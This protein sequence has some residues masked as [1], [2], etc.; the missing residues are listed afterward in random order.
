MQQ[1]GRVMRY[2]A[3]ALV[4]LG[5]AGL[6]TESRAQYPLGYYSNG[7]VVNPYV[8][9][10]RGYVRKPGEW[11]YEECTIKGSTIKVELNGTVILDCDLSKVSDYMHGSAHPGK[12]RKSGQSGAVHL[13]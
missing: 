10:Y 5:L 2:L 6:P 11:N 13:P 7:Y 1:K 4:S 9:A 12:D 8:P 3:I